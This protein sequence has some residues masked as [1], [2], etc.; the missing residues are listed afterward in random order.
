[1]KNLIV[2]L[3]LL[4]PLTIMAQ[5]VDYNK[6]ACTTRKDCVLIQ[7]GCNSFCAVNPELKETAQQLYIPKYG[8]IDDDKCMAEEELEMELNKYKAVPRRNIYAK[9]INEFCVPSCRF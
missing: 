8:K 9:C 2:L 4:S 7:T 6:M 3:I 5:T 1:M